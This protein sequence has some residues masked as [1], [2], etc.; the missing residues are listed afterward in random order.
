MRPGIGDGVED[1][2]ENQNGNTR[3]TQRVVRQKAPSLSRFRLLSLLPEIAIFWRHGNQFKPC[4]RVIIRGDHSGVTVSGVILSEVAASRS[5][6]P[7]QSKDP[8]ELR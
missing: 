7:V 5:E 8:Y 1:D 3:N 4:S 2:P 6:T